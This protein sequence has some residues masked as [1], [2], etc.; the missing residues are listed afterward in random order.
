LP[1]SYPILELG[2]LSYTLTDD[3]EHRPAQIQASGMNVTYTYDAN[4]NMTSR[5][6]GGVTYIMT[7][8]AENHMTGV[9]GTG[10]TASFTYDGDG[11]RVKSTINGSSSIYIGNYYAVLANGDTVKFYYAGSVLVARR[12]GETLQYFLTD[13][14]GSTS[15]TVGADGLKAAELRYK[16]WGEIRHTENSTPTSLRYTGQKQEPALGGADGLYYYGARWYDPYINRFT[17][18]DTI[19]PNQ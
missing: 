9:S 2:E 13:H 6:A 19:I 16:A 3:N 10:L 1:L 12:Q 7:Y 11:R 8:D 5:T 4:G 18:P 14:L 17:Q 15:I